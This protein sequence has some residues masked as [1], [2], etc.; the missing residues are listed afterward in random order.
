MVRHG[1]LVVVIAVIGK[2]NFKW[3]G[4]VVFVSAAAAPATA[5]DAITVAV[6]CLVCLLLKQL[7]CLLLSLLPCACCY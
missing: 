5:A 2:H 1:C 7:V 4:V 3:F 6:D